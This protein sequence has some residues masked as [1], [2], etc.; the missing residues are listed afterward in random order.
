MTMSEVSSSVQPARSSAT[1]YEQLL[2]S[3]MVWAEQQEQIQAV[4]EVGSRTRRDFPADKWSDLDLMLYLTDPDTFLHSTDWLASIAPVWLA[5][6]SRT[7]GDDAEL[8]VMFEGGY[9]VDFVFCHVQ[10]LVW[11]CD[12]VPAISAF[13][14]GVRLLLDRDGL[15]TA[16]VPHTFAPP[17]R[18]PPSAQDFTLA[19]DTF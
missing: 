7:A 9:N 11:L 16:V 4:I 18:R 17:L 3:F 10:A 8:L 13:D 1:V 12:N 6:P 14:R 15:A 19:C 5:I 2:A